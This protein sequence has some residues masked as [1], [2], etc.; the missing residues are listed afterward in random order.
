MEC[1][2]LEK[3]HADRVALLVEANSIYL[4]SHSKS[5]AEYNQLRAQAWDARI[6]V[7]QTQRALDLHRSICSSTEMPRALAFGSAAKG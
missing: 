2:R 5:A 7:Q 3:E 1:E 6:E 4:T